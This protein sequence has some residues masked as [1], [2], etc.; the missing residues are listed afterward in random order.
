MKRISKL[1]VSL[2]FSVF[3]GFFLV[4]DNIDNVI[5]GSLVDGVLSKQVWM[6][7]F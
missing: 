4:N 2:L 6:L 7:H 3:I 5:G 1:T